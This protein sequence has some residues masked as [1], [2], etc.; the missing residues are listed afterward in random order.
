LAVDIL[1]L[2]ETKPNQT[3]QLNLRQA[4]SVVYQVHR[5][6]SPIPEKLFSLSGISCGV[7]GESPSRW[8]VRNPKREVT[9]QIVLKFGLALIFLGAS[10]SVFCQN[11]GKESASHLNPDPRGRSIFETKCATCHGLDGLGGEHAPDIIRR[12]GAKALSDEALLNVIHD[13]FPEEGMPGFPSIGQEEAHAL[14]AYLRFLQGRSAG[15][16]VPGDPAR[17]ND[18][19]FGKARCSSC[20]QIGGRGQFATGDVAG[21]VRDHPA[22]EIRDAIL[23]PAEG[24]QE[25]ATAVAQDGRKFTGK[26]RNEDD[27]SVQLQDSDGRFYLLMK[28]SLV[29]VQ[30]KLEDPMP[31][32]YGQRLSST[33]LDDL[34]AY[35][36]RE[37]RRLDP[38]S[39][40]SAEAH[41]QD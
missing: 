40:P 1:S 7:P 18:L 26:I 35:I 3:K 11:P 21:F 27:A 31:A 17:G 4:D 37:A 12:A 22:D 29:S 6:M 9:W 38:S 13:G 34:V 15:N 16:S 24:P 14:V 20:H 33:E 36:L 5:L 25:S 10:G 28:S 2:D 23:K 32:D 30:R 39:S 8:G 41:A 19:F